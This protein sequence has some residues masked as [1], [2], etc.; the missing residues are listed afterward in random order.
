MQKMKRKSLCWVVLIAFRLMFYKSL[1]N[2]IVFGLIRFVIFKLLRRHY[3][4]R[5]VYE[6]IFAAAMI[7]KRIAV[8]IRAMTLRFSLN[9]SLTPS[10]YRTMSQARTKNRIP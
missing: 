10:P 3:L 5:E 1:V 9:M 8:E 4:N 2:F 7:I 6:P